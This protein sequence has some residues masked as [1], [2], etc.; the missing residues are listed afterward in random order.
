MQDH[1]QM[2]FTNPI[3]RGSVP[4]DDLPHVKAKS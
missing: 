3:D 4:A 2:E 1:I